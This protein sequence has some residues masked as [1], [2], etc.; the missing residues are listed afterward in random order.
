MHIDL[1]E[2]EF[3]KF[4]LQNSWKNHK[5]SKVGGCINVCMSRDSTIIEKLLVA[6]RNIVFCVVFG[7]SQ[8][9]QN[10]RLTWAYSDQ[11]NTAFESLIHKKIVLFNSLQNIFETTRKRFQSLIRY[12][13]HRPVRLIGSLKS[14]SLIFY[15]I[16]DLFRKFQLHGHVIQA[17]VAK[18]VIISKKRCYFI[19]C[20]CSH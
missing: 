14:I 5:F 15:S 18:T 6:E 10:L 8:C 12:R 2:F 19:V 1:D 20:P 16:F 11:Y 4:V 7:A 3:R 17:H 13:N 9:M